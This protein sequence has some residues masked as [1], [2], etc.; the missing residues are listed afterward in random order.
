MDIGSSVRSVLMLSAVGDIVSTAIY[1]VEAPQNPGHPH[2][3]YNKIDGAPLVDLGGSSK[4]KHSRVQI[5]C[6]TKD[7]PTSCS[8][9]AKAVYDALNDFSGD[10]DGGFIDSSTALDDGKDMSEPEL[11]EFRVMLEFSIWYTEE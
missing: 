3:V 11:E 4:T 7:D 8:A 2:I 6:Y 5:D 10:V 1:P 9:L